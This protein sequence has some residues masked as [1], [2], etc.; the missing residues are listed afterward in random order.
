ML[1]VFCYD[2]E[3]QGSSRPQVFCKK[4]F[5][6]NFAKFTGKHLC[7]SLYF[8]KVRSLRPGTLIKIE[9][10]AKVF[11]CE[12]CEISKNTFSYR[13]PPGTASD[14]KKIRT[15]YFDKNSAMSFFCLCKRLSYWQSRRQLRRQLPIVSFNWKGKILINASVDI[16][17]NMIL[18]LVDDGLNGVGNSFKLLTDKV[19]FSI[20]FKFFYVYTN[21]V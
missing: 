19:N 13:T 15:T 9:T 4:G 5:P 11:S 2:L 8:N 18:S 20:F 17:A 1:N 14:V 16:L 3:C 7:Q 6:R 21:R 12:F 10:L